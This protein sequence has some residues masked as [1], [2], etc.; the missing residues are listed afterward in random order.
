MLMPSTIY[1]LWTRTYISTLYILY[2]VFPIEVIEATN[3]NTAMV[4]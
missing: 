1:A 3:I 4:T 2:P